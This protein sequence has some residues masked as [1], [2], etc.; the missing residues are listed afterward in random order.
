MTTQSAPPS[1]RLYFSTVLRH[2]DEITC[3]DCDNEITGGSLY[4]LR[5][6]P[7][8]YVGSERVCAR[9]FNRDPQGFNVKKNKQ[10]RAAAEA[11]R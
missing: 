1:R 4:Y 8:S 7:G 10:S 9:C 6:P 2:R 11:S 5:V 3:L